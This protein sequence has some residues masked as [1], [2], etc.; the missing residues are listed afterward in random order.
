M[1][2][3]AAIHTAQ[4]YVLSEY[5]KVVGANL[6]HRWARRATCFVINLAQLADYVNYVFLYMSYRET[7]KEEGQTPQTDRATAFVSQNF[8]PG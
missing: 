8:W 1:R 3:A 2:L 6:S 4:E 7:N 5:R